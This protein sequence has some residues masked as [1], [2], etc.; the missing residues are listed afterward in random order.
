[1]RS[2]L[3]A[4]GLAL[5]LAGPALA[6]MPRPGPG[7]PRIHEVAYDPSE[8]V[9][10]RGRLGFQLTVEFDPDERIEN[11]ALGDSL[12]WQVTPNKKANLLFL[13]PMSA[14]PA[15]NMTVITNL[16][17]YNFRLSMAGRAAESTLPYAVRF[18]YEAP[19]LPVIDLTPPPTP[20]PV[21][22]NS[23]YTYEGSSKILPQRLFDDGQST[24][25]AFR[26]DG[27]FPAI[28]S[29]DPDGKEG[30]VNTYFRDGFMVV[31]RLAPGFV[32]RRGDEVTHVFNDGYRVEPPG[33][34]S[35]KPRKKD[36]WWRR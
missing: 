27:A 3:L 25:F 8:V 19:A 35:P 14:R 13:K 17:R 11:V 23:A 9:E 2:T 21:D 28:F 31:D 26:D 15:T 16:R 7:D 20:P 5:A 29:I 12:G 1:M 30:V 36:P 34:L 33:P 6:I 22:R 4:A 18:L 32:L 24:Y 10:L